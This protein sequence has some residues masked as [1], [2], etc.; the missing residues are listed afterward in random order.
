MHFAHHSPLPPPIHAHSPTRPPSLPYAH[1][2]LLI[3]RRNRKSF[4]Q[5]KINQMKKLLEAQGCV[6]GMWMR[7]MKV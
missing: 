2:S 6:C 1:F 7:T 4:K 3:S 5:M